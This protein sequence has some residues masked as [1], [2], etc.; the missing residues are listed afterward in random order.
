MLIDFI[1]HIGKHNIW[2]PSY[3]LKIN[4]MNGSFYILTL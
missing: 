1:S 2:L 3:A 4:A